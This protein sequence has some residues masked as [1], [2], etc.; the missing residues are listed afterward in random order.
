[1]NTNCVPRGFSAELYAIFFNVIPGAIS[2]CIQKYITGN[3]REHALEGA[4]LNQHGSL[5]DVG[6]RFARPVLLLHGDYGHPYSMLNLAEQASAKR[7]T[8]SLH[9]PGIEDPTKDHATTLN[10]AI[11]KIE[12]LVSDQGGVF[13]GVL[14]VGHS[15]GAI[16][17]ADSEFVRCNPNITGLFAV[18]GRFRIPAG[19]ES[20][21][22]R[23]RPLVQS[24]FA[25]IQRHFEKPLTQIIPRDDWC[26]PYA[27]MAVRPDRECY[28]VEG[29]HLSS[30]YAPAT[31]ARF[32]RF[33]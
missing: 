31:I 4:T 2:W 9:I 21:D 1:M 18:G 6:G 23:V 14:G 27:G 19:D 29:S 16:Y 17:L 20:C 11:A 5:A 3:I 8:F 13:H 26:V 25:G 32:A 33:L 30:L 12:Q 24:I 22:A 7:P 15:K 10:L 28:E